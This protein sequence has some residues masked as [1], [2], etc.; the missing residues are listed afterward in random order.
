[1]KENKLIRIVLMLVVLMVS[2]QSCTKEEEVIVDEAAT[3]D[4]NDASS[5]TIT[6][7][8]FSLSNG[9]YTAL[10]NE[11]IFDSKEECQTWSRTAQGDSHDSNPHLH[12]NAAAA[13]SYNN[14]TT[15]F[16]WTEYGPETDQTSI[17][18]TCSA[19]ANGVTKTV[20]DNSYYQDK[21]NVY[22][23]ITNVEGN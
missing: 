11:L 6:V 18:S 8:A 10:G 23:K 2:F 7:G 17:E 4:V 16:T 19:G 15:T 9:E 1:M 12:Y 22:L 20:D 21:P 14:S 5:W 13:V 3:P